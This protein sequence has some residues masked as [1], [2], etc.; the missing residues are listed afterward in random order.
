MATPPFIVKIIAVATVDSV[1]AHASAQ[2]T[3]KVIIAH[4][5]HSERTKHAHELGTCKEIIDTL[6]SSLEMTLNALASEKAAHDATRAAKD[7][8]LAAAREKTKAVMATLAATHTV[9]KQAPAAPPVAA[10]TASN[11]V[12]R[13]KD[14]NR[15]PKAR[16][17]RGGVTMGQRSRPS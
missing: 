13:L 9:Q 2:A 4:M 14:F 5:M 8:E 11:G 7:K 6:K 17:W 16:A 15:R 3:T 10:K 1:I 12:D